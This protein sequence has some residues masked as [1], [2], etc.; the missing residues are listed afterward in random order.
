[1]QSDASKIVYNSF[2]SNLYNVYKNTI[3]VVEINF[4]SFFVVEIKNYF[5]SVV[6][7]VNNPPIFSIAFCDK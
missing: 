4:H 6:I 3:F 1:M 2:V 7:L 5:M